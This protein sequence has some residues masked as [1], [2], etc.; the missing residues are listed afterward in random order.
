MLPTVRTYE[1]S[2]RA[3]RWHIPEAFNAAADS[4]DRQCRPG[5]DPD[6]T[7]LVAP[8]ADGTTAHF[9]YDALKR[10][11]DLLAS[12]FAARLL[13]PGARVATLLPHGLEM[14]LTAIA[15]LKT[16]GVIAAMDTSWSPDTL[17]SAMTAAEPRII[18]TDRA[19]LLIARRAAVRLSPAPEILCVAT[20]SDEAEDFW[21]ALYGATPTPVNVATN[22][23]AP[24]FL[25]FSQGRTGPAKP[26]L[27]AHRAVLGHLPALEMVFEDVPRPGDMLWCAAPPSHP[28]GLISGLFGAWLLGIPVL[29]MPAPTNG[30]EAES[31]FAHIARDGVRLALLTPAAIDGLR[32]FPEPRAHYSFA[33]RAAACIGGRAPQ[34]ADA[35]S[36]DTLGLPLGHL[37]GEA[38]TG[39]LAATPPHWFLSESETSIGRAIPG[40]V[41]DVVDTDGNSVPIGGIGHLA[42]TQ[43]HPGLCLGFEGPPAAAAAWAR[44]KYV[45]RWFLTDDIAELDDDGNLTFVAKADDVLP[46]EEAGFLPDDVE[47]ILTTHSMVEAAAVVA[48][49]NLRGDLEVVAAVVPKRGSAGGDAAAEALLAADLLEMAARSLAP[50]ALPKRVVFVAAIP[51]TNENR[52]H[53][54][55]LREL[56]EKRP[57]NS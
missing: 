28:M 12:A 45:G 40:T 6:R 4:L 18:V 5:A 49:P 26:L 10:L 51:R 27:H 8:M 29:A 16:G 7:A 50:Y 24:A 39:P 43:T 55:R 38:E 14:A 33:L 20:P 53:R 44:R 41:L 23:S 52:V 47:R 15:A 1:D 22:A 25:I 54:A 2:R 32:H 57:L 37:Y 46:A 30:A 42:V 34:D 56:L 17:A 48:M 21:A 36:R 3:F 13:E 31:C 19:S 35:W 11:S 9:S